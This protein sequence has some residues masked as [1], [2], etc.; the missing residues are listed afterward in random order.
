MS[1]K[2][3][4]TLAVLTALSSA[5]AF[6]ASQSHATD[7]ATPP[8]ARL[9]LNND[10][11]IDKNEAAKTP[12]LA[13]RFADLD[14][15]KDGKLSKQEMQNWAAGKHGGRHGHDVN[16]E[17]RRERMAKLDTNQDSR[18]SRAEAAAG[19]GKLAARFE[20]MDVNKDGF[21]DRAD[22]EARAKQRMDQW[23]TAAD[24]DKDGKLSRA[25]VD[26]STAKYGG[27]GGPR[28]AKPA[29]AATQ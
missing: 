24:T 16:G 1:R 20:Q 6:A 14:V 29:A 4:L 27:R 17:G 21:I 8:R 22:H 28:H 19:E 18:I 11:F 26:A 23:F 13:A 25:E 10:G 7:V 5:T 12:R 3:L 9:D 15:D 2:T